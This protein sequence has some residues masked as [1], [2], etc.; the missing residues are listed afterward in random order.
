MAALDIVVIAAGSY[1][2]DKECLDLLDSWERADIVASGR[3]VAAILV[4][5]VALT[6]DARS[7]SRSSKT[8]EAS[9]E[10]LRSS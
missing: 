3:H 7:F 10:Y 6:V 9:D 8:I 1:A 5:T 2:L 4:C